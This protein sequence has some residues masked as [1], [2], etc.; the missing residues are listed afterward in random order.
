MKLKKTC[1]SAL[2]VLFLWPS[3]LIQ[4]QSRE[5]SAFD[6]SKFVPDIAFILD[7]SG[8][9]RDIANQKYYSL[10]IPGFSYPFLN[11][12]NPS[13]LNAHRGMN[14]NYGEMS[15]YSVVDPYF[16]L[17]A[18][19]DLSPDGAGLEEAYFATR[20]LPYGFKIKVGKFLATFGRVNEQHEHYWDFA[21]RPLIATALF[22]EDGLNEIGAQVTCVA[23]TSFYLM[24]GA[25]VLNGTNEQSFGTSDINDPGSSVAINAVQGPN[26]YM[27]FIRSSFDIE[28]ASILFG[29]SNAVGA[30]RTDQGFSV[31]IG[32]AV[33][34]NTDIVGGD[35]TVKYSLDAIRFVSLQSEYIYRVMNGKEYTRD[36]LN[37]ISSPSLDKYNSG[38]YTQVA[39]KL[40]QLW[41][42][43][44]RYDLLIQN[45]VVIRSM[46]QHMPS[47]LPRYSAMIE[48]NPTEFSRL[49]I[50]FDRDE[51]RYIQSSGGLSRQPYTQII[52]QANLMIGAHGAHAF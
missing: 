42:I 3:G 8:V 24:F 17:F 44:V 15:L 26:L 41:R 21:N 27:G 51:S 46:D 34:A 29:I 5:G 37:V 50:Q 1:I 20:K 52:L 4:A 49:R 30:T 6:Q 43:G 28:D 31:G 13:G 11:Q 38:F 7:I 23:P 45:D 48:Y 32:N 47:N 35:L 10:T 36:S 25:E 18:V 39:A 40:N 33:D 19:L 14:F 16:D 12:P 9:A 22:G 2:V